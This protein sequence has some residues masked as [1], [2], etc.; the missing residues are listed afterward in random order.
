MTQSFDHE[1]PHLTKKIQDTSNTPFNNVLKIDI[2]DSLSA[3]MHEL[4]L[5]KP[6]QTVVSK[7]PCALGGECRAKLLV[8]LEC[9]G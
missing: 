1:R 6:K 7:I 3:T 5:Y 2:D 8:G 4:Q 9:G